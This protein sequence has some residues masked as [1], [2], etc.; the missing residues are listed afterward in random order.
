LV[1]LKNKRIILVVLAIVVLVLLFLIRTKSRFEAQVAQNGLIRGDATL[2]ETVNK[3]TD[4]DGVLD[5]EERLWGTDPTKSDTNDD[6]TPDS[7]E[8]TK[9]KETRGAT[10]NLDGG[11]EESLSQ[12]DRFS[13]ELFSTVVALNQAGEID[14]ATTEKITSSLSEK[15]K[16][17]EQKR[18]F[19][20]SEIKTTPDNSSTAFNKYITQIADIYKKH[21]AGESVIE[22]LAEFVNDGANVNP[23]ALLKLGSVVEQTS[24]V[25][26][27]LA[28][29]SVP[30]EIG[31]LHLELLN[32]LQKLK[33][34]I[35]DIQLYDADPII[36]MGAVSQY[37]ANTETL[38]EV[39]VKLGNKVREKLNN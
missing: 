5:W 8:I 22:I 24:L 18:V 31:P 10:T 30:S 23:D 37:E 27:E 38:D 25:L 12:T 39:L 6:G 26:E 7:V 11:E 2:A 1:W 3:D 20:I 28:R 17:V 36:A 16:N 15:I 32:A 33:E 35:S 14:Q 13:R 19:L 34:N 21:P 9:L 4:L 29:M